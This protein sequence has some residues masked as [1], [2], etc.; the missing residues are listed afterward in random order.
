MN[1]D[2]LLKTFD[3]EDVLGM[4]MI[5]AFNLRPYGVNAEVHNLA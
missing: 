4:V 1:G 2:H 3:Y 5:V